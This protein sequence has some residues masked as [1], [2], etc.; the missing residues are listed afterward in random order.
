[1][2]A[3]NV[4]FGIE[5]ECF[6]P[7]DVAANFTPGGYHRGLPIQMAPTGWN[8]QYDGS[9]HGPSGYTAVEVVSPVLAGEAGLTE[10]VYMVEYLNEVGAVVNESCGLHVHVNAAGLT[11]LQIQRVYNAFRHYE[12]AFYGLS[13]EKAWERMQSTYCRPSHRWDSSRYQSLNL[14]NVG[15]SRKN[16]IEV[17][18]FSGTLDMATVVTAIYMSVALVARSVDRDVNPRRM[19]DP[20]RAAD[21]FIRHNLNNRRFYIVPDAPADEVKETLTAAA[22]AASEWRNRMLANLAA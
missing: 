19:T 4:K 10:A 21:S 3:K 9:L 12:M 15:R 20:G 14:T 16:T 18:C 11:P 7:T 13:G 17:R 6:V 22:N 2:E 8:S 5:I 1:M